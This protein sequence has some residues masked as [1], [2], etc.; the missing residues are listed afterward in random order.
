M[1]VRVHVCVCA[2]VCVCVCVCACV[3][4]CVRACVCMCVCMC[5]CTCVCVCVCVWGG[6]HSLISDQ[7]ST[8]LTFDLILVQEGPPGKESPT[9]ESRC[10]LLLGVERTDIKIALS[11]YGWKEGHGKQREGTGSSMSGARILLRT[12]IRVV[13]FETSIR[14]CG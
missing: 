6:G 3:C 5:A 12:Y 13:A 11:E 8:R 1:S 7:H 14:S 4:A 9:S 2:R 10:P